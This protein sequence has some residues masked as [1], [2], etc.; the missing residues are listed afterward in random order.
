MYLILNGKIGLYKRLDEE[1]NDEVIFLSEGNCF[2]S[3]YN[4][5]YKF[6]PLTF[7]EALIAV[8]PMREI[9]KITVTLSIEREEMI[10]AVKRSGFCNG[11]RE[12]LLR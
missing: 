9:N 10:G 11:V 7:E 2:G 12:D 6:L 3:I 4:W 5:K 1:H 8:I